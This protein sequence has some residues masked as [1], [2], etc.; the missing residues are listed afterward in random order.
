MI[1]QYKGVK[2]MI[3]GGTGRSGT[4]QF[5]D[6]LS[7][8]PDITLYGEIQRSFQRDLLT[9]AN[10]KQRMAKGK[11]LERWAKEK[12]DFLFN[13]WRVLAKS[14]LQP[15]EAT[16]FMGHKTPSSELLFDQYEEFFST[17]ANKP[18]YFYCGR[19]FVDTW[20]SFRTMK[21]NPYRT[22]E[23]FAAFYKESWSAFEKMTNAVPDRVNLLN[24]DAFAQ[25]PDKVEFC[26]QHIFSPLGL[27]V[28]AELAE[29][30][31]NVQNR[32]SSA[33]VLGV[34]PVQ[35]TPAEMSFA[36]EDQDI[37]RIRETFFN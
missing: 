2:P 34:E 11:E 36:N 33:N 14:S 13:G 37:G 35:I 3:V 24:L 8:H 29:T 28:D 27:A 18:M 10:R 26:R 30:I 6:I 4:R 9:L 12:L 7:L 21:W 20:R 5:A 32:N 1:T 17:E 16:S 31:S 25:S 15:G 19:N 22:I 23:E